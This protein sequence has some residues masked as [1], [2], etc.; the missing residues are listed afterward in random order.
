M[1]DIEVMKL[2]KND[3]I[4]AVFILP[5][6]DFNQVWNLIQKRRLRFQPADNEAKARAAA[7]VKTPDALTKGAAAKKI[8]APGTACEG[9]E[10]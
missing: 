3:S 7:V 6:A 4:M 5:I 2:I 10:K 9:I 1:T 8:G